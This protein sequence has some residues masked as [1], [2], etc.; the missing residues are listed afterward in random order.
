M[1]V[2]TNTYKLHRIQT[3]Q[4]SDEFRSSRNDRRVID[5]ARQ[6]SRPWPGRNPISVEHTLDL[7]SSSKGERIQS[8]SLIRRVARDDV[9]CSAASNNKNK[10][11]YNEAAS[12]TGI[13]KASLKSTSEKVINKRRHLQ[14]SRM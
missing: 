1:E 3:A 4:A 10:T 11:I 13:N 8:R 5:S 12:L 2:G 6:A 9:F 14:T 7:C